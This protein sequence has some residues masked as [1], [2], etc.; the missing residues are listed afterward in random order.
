MAAKENTQSQPTEPRSGAA[1]DAIAL[2]E[3]DHREVEAL[4]EA[5]ESA[6]DAD[7]KQRIVAALKH[8]LDVHTQIEEEIFYPTARTFIQ[9]DEINE[10][11]VEH[12]AAETLLR[13]LVA[14]TPDDPLYAAKVE[15]LKEQI[16]HHVGEEEEDIFPELRESAMD[17]VA[18]G[19]KMETRKR[20]LQ[21]EQG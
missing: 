12:G 19:A 10:A 9:D 5:F 20:E 11:I 13:E 17:I 15:V 8:A 21:A 6:V 4:F 1:L 14:M 16:E 18:V 3:S 2:L 7:D